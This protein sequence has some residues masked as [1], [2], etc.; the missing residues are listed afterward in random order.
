MKLADIARIP[1]EDILEVVEEMRDNAASHN[2]LY[3]A[4]MK[5]FN[6]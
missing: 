6:D 5:T 1:K 3:Q 2:R 4:N